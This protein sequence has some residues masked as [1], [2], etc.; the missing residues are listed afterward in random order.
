MSLCIARSRGTDRANVVSKK[1]LWR[2]TAS[3]ESSLMLPSRRV[4]IRHA[5]A[6]M[7]E[8]SLCRS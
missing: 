4:V 2:D 5:G 7:V 6:G 3:L 8:H 1:R